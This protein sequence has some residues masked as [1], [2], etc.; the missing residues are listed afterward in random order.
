M[1]FDI[2]IHGQMI[3][4]PAI[5]PHPDIGTKR[6]CA[7]RFIGFEQPIGRKHLRSVGG[8]LCGLA[9]VQQRARHHYL[10]EHAPLSVVPITADS[11]T[12][13][14]RVG[15]IVELTV[16]QRIAGNRLCAKHLAHTAIVRLVVEIAH[17]HNQRIGIDG[18][19]TI[20]RR[21]QLRCHKQSVRFALQF[22]TQTRREMVDKQMQC[23]AVGQRSARI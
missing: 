5:E 22:T 9:T 8:Q 4:V 14:Q 23:I 19:H 6:F 20:D 12:L 7:K 1:Q 13:V 21:P 17:D 10:V 11:A 3:A 2:D 16:G 18:L 15:E